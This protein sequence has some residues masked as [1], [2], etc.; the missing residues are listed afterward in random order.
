[1][2]FMGFILNATSFAEYDNKSL[3][4][5]EGNMKPSHGSFMNITKT[6]QAIT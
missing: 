2:Q 6:I 3:F 4:R 1:M 5:K